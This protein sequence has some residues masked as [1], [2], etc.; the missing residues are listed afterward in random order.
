MSDSFI[1]DHGVLKPDLSKLIGDSDRIK[2]P[3]G[4]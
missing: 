1:F 4:V 2:S 3:A